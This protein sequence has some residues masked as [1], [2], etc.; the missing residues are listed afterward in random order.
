MKKVRFLNRNGQTIMMSAV[1]NFPEGVDESRK[2][3]AVV[4]SHPGGGVKGGWDLRKEA[5]RCG[6][7]H[8][9]L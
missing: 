8:D 6:I 9:R 1:L 3:A 5:C 7:R 4:V 2:Y